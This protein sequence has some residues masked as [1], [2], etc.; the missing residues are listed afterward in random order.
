MIR[1]SPSPLVLAGALALATW[2]AA[3]AQDARDP[4][5]APQLDKASNLYSVTPTFYRSAKLEPADVARL[6][7]L[8]VK[9]VVSLR[10]F[11]SDEVLLAD[12]GI[13]TVQIPIYTWKIRDEQV[14]QALRAIRSAE[15]DG[16]VLLHCLHGADRT[17]LVTAMYRIIYQQRSK[18]QAVDELKH[19]G[20]GYHAIWK[21]IDSYLRKVDVE[22]IRRR[23]AQP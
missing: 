22:A 12:S 2:P 17:G 21:N 5:W 8:G 13:K 1:F 3:A 18:E 4:L 11:H 6:Q 7:A 15:R 19:G 20:Y 9:T 10:A 23:V 14:V 16:A